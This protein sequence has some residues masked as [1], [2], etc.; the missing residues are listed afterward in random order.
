[1]RLVPARAREGVLF[2]VLGPSWAG[3]SS[4][5]GGSD[6]LGVL[7]R[8]SRE[9]ADPLAIAVKT[10]ASPPRRPDCLRRTAPGGT[11][12]A[13][14]NNSDA[15]V[16]LGRLSLWP[17]RTEGQACCTPLDVS[18]LLLWWNPVWPAMMLFSLHKQDAVV[19]FASVCVNH[20]GVWLQ[21][22]PR[23]TVRHR[24]FHLARAVPCPGSERA[25]H[26][27]AHTAKASI[28][29]EHPSTLAYTRAQHDCLSTSFSCALRSWL[30][31]AARVSWC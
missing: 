14:G 19:V 18:A 31:P 3:Q 6:P 20:H 4:H 13:V 23:Q 22:E 9:P 21:C 10:C 30:S 15:C 28:V 27:Q 8:R 5:D 11:A 29:C 2:R 7:P 24:P 26:L 16:V 12:A 25:A 17:Q 1:M